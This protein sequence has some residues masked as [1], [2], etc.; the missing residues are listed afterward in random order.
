MFYPDANQEEQ[1]ETLDLRKVTDAEVGLP[2]DT[3]VFNITVSTISGPP[4]AIMKRSARY[5]LYCQ[6]WL[7]AYRVI[8]CMLCVKNS[9]CFT[10]GCAHDAAAHAALVCDADMSCAIVLQVHHILLKYAELHVLCDLL[11]VLLL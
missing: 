1:E 3:H 5:T 4:Q 2:L 10:S 7:E 8:V 6:M 11:T 9:Y